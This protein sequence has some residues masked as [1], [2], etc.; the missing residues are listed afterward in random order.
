MR[1]WPKISS[2]PVSN[3]TWVVVGGAGTPAVAAS[4][5]IHRTDRRARLLEVDELQLALSFP[6][7]KSASASQAAQ[8]LA[9]AH[10]PKKRPGQ[11]AKA[12]KETRGLCERSSDGFSLATCWKVVRHERCRRARR[13]ERLQR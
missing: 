1:V 10:R 11:D 3:H 7:K 9:E 8:V 13:F 2:N 6:W 4:T 12:Q 5:P